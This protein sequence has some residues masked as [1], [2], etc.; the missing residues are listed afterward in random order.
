MVATEQGSYYYHADHLGSSSVVTD[1]AGKFYEHLEY[2][3]YGET[4]VHNKATSEQT[5]TPYKFTSKELDEETG[6]YYFG[7][8]YYEPR[9][10]RWISADN[11]IANGKYLPL[12]NNKKLSGMGGVFNTI[13]L[14][15]YHYAGQNPVK[16]LDPDGNETKSY[17]LFGDIGFIVGTGCSIQMII[18][19]DGNYGFSASYSI[20]VS[21]PNASLHVG[22]EKTSADTMYD[23]S[24]SSTSVSFSGSTVVGVSG[25]LEYSN[26]D[27]SGHGLKVSAGAAAGTPVGITVAKNETLVAGVNVRTISDNILQMGK[28]IK[29]IVKSEKDIS[30]IL[31]KTKNPFGYKSGNGASGWAKKNEGNGD[32]S[33]FNGLVKKQYNTI[34]D[35]VQKNKK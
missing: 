3:P 16:F 33:Y 11:Y 10:S 31:S 29:D 32:T 13:N 21:A 25:A 12:G 28:N 35:S 6:L 9:M 4:W 2:F 19:D 23:T 5:S 27:G 26:L 17:G 14:D 34:M 22:A 8:R 7:A 30:S 20:A 18:D 1:K 15:A 24:G